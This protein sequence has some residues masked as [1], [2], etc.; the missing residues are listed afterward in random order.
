VVLSDWCG[1]PGG[2]VVDLDRRDFAV[3][4][5]PSVGVLPVTVSAIPA[6]PDTSTDD[7]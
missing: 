3:L 6:P 7:D 2:R 4:A 1:C 5:P